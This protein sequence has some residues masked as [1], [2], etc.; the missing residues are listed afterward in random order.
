[1]TG[2]PAADPATQDGRRARPPRRALRTALASAVLDRLLHH[3]TVVNIKSNSFRLRGK[4]PEPIV[5]GV[6]GEAP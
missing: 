6:D 3:S 4:L 2:T 1:M 5:S